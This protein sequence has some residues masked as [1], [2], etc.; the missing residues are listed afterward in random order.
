M[1]IITILDLP[2]PCSTAPKALDFRVA[3]WPAI[4]AAL[5][6]QL[7]AKSPA[8]HIKSK[9][10]FIEKV[11]MVVHIILET[12]VKHLNEK[13][14]NPFKKCWWTK[15]LTLLKKAQNCL[16][17]KSFKLWHLHEHPIHVEHW[18]SANKFKEV[19]CETW[20]QDWK[21][22]LE[23]ISQQDLYITNKYITS[24]PTNYSCVC[25]PSL[26]TTFNSLPFLTEENTDKVTALAESF[27]P[28]PPATSHVPPNQVYPTPL[29]G[30]C[31]FSRV[32][33]RQV[34]CLL[35]P[36]KVP[37]LDKIP[38]IVLMKC[39]DALIDH[40]F[41]IFRAVLKLKVYHPNWLESITLVLH[42][43]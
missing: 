20:E 19:M 43:I 13:C 17:S 39:V 3:D 2:L 21:D 29:N 35:S 10:E 33:I 4:N 9:E 16:S 5:T 23:S 26:N 31:F 25:I 14:P 38:N 18:T 7:E 15:E 37:G 11:S 30:L 28:P 40:L 24:K 8:L 41:F 42:K 34:I 32:R 12:L 36:Y 27:F 6:A 22:W 1:P